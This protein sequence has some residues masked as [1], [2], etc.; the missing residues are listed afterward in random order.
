MVDRGPWALIGFFQYEVQVLDSSYAALVYW[1]IMPHFQC[2]E[3]G[4]IPLCCTKVLDFELRMKKVR[5]SIATVAQRQSTTLPRSGLRFRNS[6]V[7]QMGL[8][9]VKEPSRQYKTVFVM[10]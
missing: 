4:S 7:A 9:S 1:L 8:L 3:E 5:K 2:G 6:S 10:K